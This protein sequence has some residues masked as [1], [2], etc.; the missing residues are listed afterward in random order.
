MRAFAWRPG[1]V[2]E[3]QKGDAYKEFWFSISRNADLAGSDKTALGD[4]SRLSDIVQM[5]VKV[6]GNFSQRLE[7]HN[8]PFDVQALTLRLRCTDESHEVVVHSKEPTV[9]P[10]RLF[11]F[12]PTRQPFMS[13]ACSPADTTLV[14]YT[15]DRKVRAEYA[16]VRMPRRY[17]EKFYGELTFSIWVWREPK[18]WLINYLLVV[19]VVVTI[20]WSC[21]SVPLAATGDRL[22]IVTTQILSLVAFKA[23]SEL[24]RLDYLTWMDW[25]VNISLVFLFTLALLVTLAPYFYDLRGVNLDAPAILDRDGDGNLD[26]GDSSSASFSHLTHDTPLWLFVFVLWLAFNALWFMSG[27]MRRDFRRQLLDIFAA[28]GQSHPQGWRP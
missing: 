7:L 25:Y 17:Q 11:S 3:S 12:E 13:L 19:F 2:L 10:D 9:G 18:F 14:E 5:R 22:A 6:R 4:P 26:N 21:M 8:F 15:F 23:N 24:P 16:V 27:W 28:T 20:G 1:F